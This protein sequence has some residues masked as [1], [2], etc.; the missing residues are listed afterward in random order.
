MTSPPLSKRGASIN[1]MAALQATMVQRGIVPEVDSSSLVQQLLATV[2]DLRVKC[3]VSYA[4]KINEDKMAA[5]KAGAMATTLKS[6]HV[7]PEVAAK[8]SAVYDD[9]VAQ[10][11]QLLEETYDRSV[12]EMTHRIDQF[13]HDLTTQATAS[14][15]TIVETLDSQHSHDRLALES[16]IKDMHEENDHQRANLVF[17][18]RRLRALE[19]ATDLGD[20]E[21]CNKLR[22][23]VAE[24][25]A[26]LDAARTTCVTAETA[27]AQAKR[28]I[29]R[30]ES[31]VSML[32]AKMQM[33][34]GM[35]ARETSQLCD[36][37]RMNEAQFMQ[38]S[39][40][41]SSP[42]QT[43]P[44]RSGRAV[45]VYDPQSG[46]TVAFAASAASVVAPAGTQF[47]A[48]SSPTKPPARPLSPTKPTSPTHRLSSTAARAMP[49]P[50]ATIQR[51]YI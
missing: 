2:H 22:A 8:F 50:T 44:T 5:W 51:P 29:F 40:A 13:E 9:A 26:A 42:R 7:T 48:H 37:I 20:V 39:M 14:Q 19:N 28:V 49:V 34:Q 30:L 35:Y 4:F 18:E 41:A 33:T 38:V 31:D 43:S 32:R 25:E 3:R 10:M 15:T 27:H 23:R 24:L 12:A 45:N 1:P 17:M 6:V 36:I 11:R 21:L 16:I 46:R 47:T